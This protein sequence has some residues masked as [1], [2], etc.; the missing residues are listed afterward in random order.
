MRAQVELPALGIAFVLLTA[1]LV[2]GISVANDALT[3]SERPALEREAAVSLSDRLVSPEAP[4]TTR[5][6][7]LRAPAVENLNASVLRQQYG[8]EDGDDVEVRLGEQTISRAG[9]PR[10]G[11]TVRRLV[12]VE[13]RQT[14]RLVP[15][16]AASSSAAIPRRAENVRVNITQTENVTVRAVEANEETVLRNESGLDGVF[17]V[18]I[19]ELETTTLSFEVAGRRTEAGIEIAYETTETRKATLAVT[20]DG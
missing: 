20:V 3:T 2:L 18:A 10:S 7:V 5:A 17:S 12:L 6:N 4:V 13:R 14:Q 16:L 15:D 1:A 9:E 19:S 11:T 8:L